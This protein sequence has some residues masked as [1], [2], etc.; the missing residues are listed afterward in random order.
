MV[1]V[2]ATVA[3]YAPTASH[4][5]I[6]YDDPGYV[7]GNELVRSGLTSGGIAWAF[8]ST[9]MSNWH[10]VTW[11]SHMLDVQLF[12]LKPAGHHLVSVALHVA[13]SLLLLL[14]L[15]RLTGLPGRSLTVAALFALHPLHVESVAWVA[16]RKDVLSGLLWHLTLLLWVAHVRRP[17]PGRYAG[18][19]ACFALGLLAKPMLVTLPVVLLLL[20]WWPLG[21]CRGGGEGPPGKG[22]GALRLPPLLEKV[23]FFLLAAASSAVTIF[24]QQRG[25]SLVDLPS[26][27]IGL[28]VAN[29][30]VSTARYV[31]KAL[32]PVDLAVLYPLPAA[33]PAWQ[34]LIAAAVIVAA[35]ATAVALARRLPFLV[36][37]WFWFLVT[38]LPVIG[39]VQVGAQ[40]MADRYTY[41]PLTGLF[42]V[43]VW[44]GAELM[45]P[46]RHGRWVA[47]GAAAATLAAAAAVTATQLGH[48]RDSLAL[49]RHTLAV[50]RDNFLIMNNYGAALNDA[51]KPEEAIAVLE[52]AIATAPTHAEAYYNL[53]RIAQ[54]TRQDYE[55]AGALYARALQLKPDYADALINL[56]GLLNT[57]GRFREGLELLQRARSLGRR[58]RPELRFNLGVSYV[59]LGNVGAALQEAEALRRLDPALARQ[60]LEFI[61]ERTGGAGR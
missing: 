57:A 7:T 37:G 13:S 60:L 48:W 38:L 41:L 55:A 26:A 40:A 3:A 8:T 33:I 29:A 51:G 36:T 23:P 4:D 14:L 27:P 2:L 53:G 52:Q 58:E 35:S 9:A 19:L 28:R 56:G 45:A 12:G 39:L 61:G 43:V 31:G 16:E 42:I 15:V 25:G 20:D 24:A 49:Y 30:L 50:T 32:W 46:L 10:P 18:A 17:G 44:G 21:R 54:V 22:A 1:M 34:P 6:S 59:S 5:F 47:T 11:L